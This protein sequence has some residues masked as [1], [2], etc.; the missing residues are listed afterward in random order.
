MFTIKLGSRR[1]N[2]HLVGWRR[3]QTAFELYRVTNDVVDHHHRLRRCGGGPN[4][5]GIVLNGV[6]V[7]LKCESHDE[8]MGGV[9]LT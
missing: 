1:L 5:V 6:E 2:Q 7:D 9:C 4:V 8:L 3:D